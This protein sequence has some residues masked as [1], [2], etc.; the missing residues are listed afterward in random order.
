MYQNNRT[1]LSTPQILT[2]FT[3]T[4]FTLLPL[5]NIPLLMVLTEIVSPMD[6]FCSVT[7]DQPLPVQNLIYPIKI[8]L[9]RN[10]ISTL[11]LWLDHVTVWC[12]LIFATLTS[13]LSYVFDYINNDYKLLRIVTMA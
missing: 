4:F 1:P 3:L 6:F 2:L 12:V 9:I 8:L 7:T 11:N 13:L 5:L 10:R